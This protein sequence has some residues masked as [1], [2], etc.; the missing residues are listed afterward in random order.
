MDDDWP[1]K[2]KTDHAFPHDHGY[3]FRGYHLDSKQRPTFIYHYGDIIVEDFFEDR[4]TKDGVAIFNRTFRFKTPNH[5]SLFYFRAGSGKSIFKKSNRAFD[6][7]RLQLR[8]ISDHQ[9]LVREGEPGEVLIPLTLPQGN[10][11]LTLEY[12]W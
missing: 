6:V 2:G 11:T 4:L 5:Q 3:Q 8:I 1:Y 10:S 12:Q 7:D 9:G